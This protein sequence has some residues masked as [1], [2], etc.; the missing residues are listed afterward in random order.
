[1]NTVKRIFLILFLVVILSCEKQN[2]SDPTLAP[3]KETEL[4]SIKFLIGENFI[5][6]EIINDS[7]LINTVYG[8]EDTDNVE[9]AEWEFSSPAV[10]EPGLNSKLVFKENNVA[11]FTISSE[12]GPQKKV[13]F[14]RLNIEKPEIN[15]YTSSHFLGLGILDSTLN[16]D[17]IVIEN[18]GDMD[19]TYSFGDV[20]GTKKAVDG[21]LYFRYEDLKLEYQEDID[22]KLTTRGKEMVIANFRPQEVRHWFDLQAIR[23]FPTKDYILINDIVVDQP[24]KQIGNEEGPFIGKFDGGG[25]TISNFSNLPTYKDST[26]VGMFGVLGQGG[27]ISNFTLDLYSFFYAGKNA[28]CLVGLNKGEISKV[29]VINAN[30]LKGPYVTKQ[31]NIGGIVGLNQGRILFCSFDG[32]IHQAG[33]FTGGICGA[34]EG[35]ISSCYS[36]GTVK[37]FADVCGGIAGVN[38]GDIANCF[39]TSRVEVDSWIAGGLVGTNEQGSVSKSFASGSIQAKN[40]AGGLI[41]QNMGGV[42]GNCVA[43]NSEIKGNVY[44]EEDEFNRVAAL[45]EGELR[46]NGAL[47]SM[48]VLGTTVSSVD[49]NNIS[50][51]DIN[52]NELT[53][54][55]FENLGWDFINIWRWDDDMGRPK[56]AGV[57]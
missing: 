45:N 37:A 49:E 2:D 7:I 24:L 14:V 35:S 33:N 57:K 10:G 56:L 47:S 39:S 41:G 50:G 44:T 40:R 13:Y 22:L 25:F 48:L 31:R 52:E 1:M 12:L 9:I 32:D 8:F 51:A 55:Y 53:Q 26:N 30:I 54:V 6:G 3:A 4:V 46:N 27:E 29:R 11:N 19:H 34:N 15:T 18:V 42:V 43:L 20:K 16:Y 28:G 5:S 38:R 36:A 21:K 23:L 17:F